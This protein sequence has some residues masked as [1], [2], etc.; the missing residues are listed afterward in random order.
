MW[1]MIIE[2]LQTQL[3]KN[4]ADSLPDINMAKEET[5][6]TAHLPRAA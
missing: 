2:N 6:D 1:D 3:K 5:P 4:S